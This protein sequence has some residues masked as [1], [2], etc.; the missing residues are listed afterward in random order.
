MLLDTKEKFDISKAAMELQVVYD[1]LLQLKEFP[2]VRGNLIER[3]KKKAV[4][5]E[6]L[7]REVYEKILCKHI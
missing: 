1:V 5:N 4:N 6:Y 7:N 3:C 2:D